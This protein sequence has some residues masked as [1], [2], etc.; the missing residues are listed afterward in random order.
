VGELYKALVAT[1]SADGLAGELPT[2]QRGQPPKTENLVPACVAFLLRNYGVEHKEIHQ[3]LDEYV[4]D[5]TWK[6]H[7]PSW[8]RDFFREAK[9]GTL[10]N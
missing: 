9:T 2:R 7:L 1:A 4:L 6:S 8:E 5:E 3:L 10:K